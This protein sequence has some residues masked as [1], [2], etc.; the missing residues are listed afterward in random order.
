MG[1]INQT[2]GWNYMMR[3]NAKFGTDIAAAERL[4][5]LAHARFQEAL[6]TDGKTGFFFSLFCSH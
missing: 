6:D 2:I 4:L 5:K 1:I 3:A